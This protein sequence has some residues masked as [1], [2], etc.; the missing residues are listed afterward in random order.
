MHSFVS[1]LLGVV[2]YRFPALRDRLIAEIPRRRDSGNEKIPGASAN[3]VAL[4]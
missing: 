4:E 2:H 1:D 3:F